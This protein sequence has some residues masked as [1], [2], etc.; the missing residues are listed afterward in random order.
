MLLLWKMFDSQDIMGFTPDEALRAWELRAMGERAS[1]SFF[2]FFFLR[3]QSHISSTKY[4]Y[5]VSRKKSLQRP[6][7]C[8]HTRYVNIFTKTL[9]MN[10]PSF[11]FLI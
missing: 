2:F 7:V 4:A 3:R 6:G 11:F 10:H 8:K 5:F 9:Q 1:Q